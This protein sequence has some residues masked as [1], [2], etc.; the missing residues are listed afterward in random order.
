MVMEQ[1][2]ARAAA[3]KA[4]REQ[5]PQPQRDESAVRISSKHF[6]GLPPW[7]P[8]E[9]RANTP[10]LNYARIGSYADLNE[11]DF[12]MDGKSSDRA[13]YVDDDDEQPQHSFRSQK[14]TSQESLE[15]YTHKKLRTTESGFVD[16][17]SSPPEP[18]QYRYDNS[19]NY[20]PTSSLDG[21]SSPSRPFSD[22]TVERFPS[23]KGPAYKYGA[24][25]NSP[26][27][28]T[29]YTLDD[30]SPGQRQVLDL[31]SQGKNVFF[32]GS[33]G[34][35]KSFVLQKITQ[36]LKSQRLKQFSDFFITA[37]TGN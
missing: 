22:R 34:V 20:Y 13:Y 1:Q 18:Y 33:A 31:V 36:L 25:P 3:E 19:T 8:S 5:N 29:K 37:S 35:G 11:D 15:S 4:V 27:A 26:P 32:T 28:Y 30:C 16:L 6:D 14:R 9:A 17:T 21:S 23:S 10:R 7:N 2:D 12:V 24:S